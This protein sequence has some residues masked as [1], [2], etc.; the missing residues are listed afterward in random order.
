MREKATRALHHHHERL[1]RHIREP[2]NGVSHGAGAILAV[3]GLIA[4]LLAGN[5]RPWHTVG[6]AIYG[7][8]LILV[9]VASTLYHS[10]HV[11]KEGVEKLMAIDQSAIFL[12]IAGSY[13]PVCLVALRGPLGWSILGIVWAI[14]FA[15]IALRWGWKGAPPWLP[16]ALYL[17]MGWMALL[18]A[19][20]LAAALPPTAMQWLFG[21]GVIYTVGAV[22]FA[23]KRPRLWPGMFSSHEL[24]HV[25]VLGGSGCHFVMMYFFVAPIN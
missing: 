1:A 24:W 19:Q 2:F 11:S 15:G 9:Y 17:G 13:T 10:L 8:T 25:F 5:G 3:I 14:C 20:P 6:F 22:I 21:G 18:A 12:V 16:V 7:T 23:A 4:L